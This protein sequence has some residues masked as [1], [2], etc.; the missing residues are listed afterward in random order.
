ATW[1][2]ASCTPFPYSTLFRSDADPGE[3]GPPPRAWRALQAGS[4]VLGLGR[5]TSTCVESTRTAASPGPIAPDHLHVRG[6][7]VEVST[8]KKDRKST[9]LNSSH[10][11][12]SYAV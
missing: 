3:G 12:I 5:T 7:H 2:P 6:E 4:E 1:W 11:T 10:V 8:N 9:R